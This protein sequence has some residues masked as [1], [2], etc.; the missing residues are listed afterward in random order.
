M[1]ENARTADGRA[2]GTKD[3]VRENGIDAF[4]CVAF[5]AVVMIHAIPGRDPQAPA[6]GFLVVL[7]RFAVP[8]FFLASGYFLANRG[9]VDTIVRTARRLLPIYLVWD[10]F[11]LLEIDRGFDR[12]LAPGSALRWLL[13]GQPGYHLWFLTALGTSIALFAMARSRL[14]WTALFALASVL[15]AAGLLLGSWR[16]IVGMGDMPFNTRNGP[17]FGFFFVLA[18][19]WLRAHDLRL[20]CSTA[21]ICFVSSA[22]L[23]CAEAM[24][25]VRYGSGL[26]PDADFLLSTTVFG[27]SSFMLA[28]SLPQNRLWS[29][30]SLL[31]GATLGM[32]LIHPAVLAVVQATLRPR[33]LGGQLGAWYLTVI[34]SAAL[35]SLLI[36]F[37]PLRRVMT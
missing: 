16:D 1:T 20:R 18:G 14:G 3:R 17:F 28:R 8:F 27:I 13:L 12:L 5:A 2:A 37:P 31:G 24:L 32:Y 7:S 10:L 29:A 35:A 9:A 11:Y 25:F 33:D 34:V 15:Y 22:G 30:L 19:N 4:R 6:E 23:Q 36:R 26:L 21:A